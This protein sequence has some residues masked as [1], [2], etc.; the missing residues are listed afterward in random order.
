[1][2]HRSPRRHALLYSSNQT[3]KSSGAGLSQ[4]SPDGDIRKAH[5]F[6]D[7]FNLEHS[8]YA[9]AARA[10]ANEFAGLRNGFVRSQVLPS[11]VYLG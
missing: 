1:M 10:N 2:N 9:A 8:A 3:G 6:V 5:S 11:C 7:D 4:Q